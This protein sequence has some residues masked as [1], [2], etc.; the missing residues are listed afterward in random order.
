M[1]YRQ[2]NKKFFKVDYQSRILYC[3]ARYRAKMFY[4]LL[5]ELSTGFN[6][7]RGY[8]AFCWW[9]MA[10]DDNRNDFQLAYVC[11]PQFA[12]IITEVNPDVE[13]THSPV[14]FSDELFAGYTCSFNLLTF[15]FDLQVLF[16][17]LSNLRSSNARLFLFI[18]PSILVAAGSVR[19]SNEL[20]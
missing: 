13:L 12:R 2:L 7:I 16:V 14:E 3:F 18:V 10:L 8:G 4:S 6:F 19:I 1:N 5:R 20:S 17:A 11:G 15:Y 9:L